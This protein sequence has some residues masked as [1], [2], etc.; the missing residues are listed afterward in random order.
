VQEK[1]GT[2]N[3]F[4]GMGEADKR[5]VREYWGIKSLMDFPI[6]KKWRNPFFI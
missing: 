3:G 6:E 2:G 1:G 5:K 4:L